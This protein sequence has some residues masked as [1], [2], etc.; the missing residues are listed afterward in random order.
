MPDA[1][2]R[3]FQA[4]SLDYREEITGFL[5]SGREARPLGAQPLLDVGLPASSQARL[6]AAAPRI[7]WEPE[8]S[9]T[10]RRPT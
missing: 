6:T 4:P 1:F 3:E 9:P 10:R 8:G 7:R 5:S 2:L